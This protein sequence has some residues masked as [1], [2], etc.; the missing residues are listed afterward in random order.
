MELFLCIIMVYVVIV[1][2]RSILFDTYYWN[3]PWSTCYVHKSKPFIIFCSLWVAYMDA[4][5]M[6]KI[7]G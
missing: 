5:T 1:G 6:D 2:L 7:F 4:S 3:L